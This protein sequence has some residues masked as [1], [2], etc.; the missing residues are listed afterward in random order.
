MGK[1]ITIK[2]AQAT[3]AVPVDE[4]ALNQM[5]VFLEHAGRR[6]AA[7]ISA[8]EFE[9]FREWRTGRSWPQQQLDRLQAERTAFQ[10]LLPELLKTRA[11]QFVALRDGRLID[12]DTDENV[13]AQRIAA[14]GFDR[15]Y[16]QEVRA[17]PRI[18]ELSSPEIVHHVP[19]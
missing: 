8:D 6:V 10:R 11:G 14:R 19:V 16:I 7:I 12:A 9:A 17:E 2:E 15:I 3:Y 13:L 1:I 4:V 18:Y 5:P